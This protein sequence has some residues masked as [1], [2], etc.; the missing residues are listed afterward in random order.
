MKLTII[1]AALISLS[2]PALAKPG[3]GGGVDVKTTK[4][5]SA[6]TKAALAGVGNAEAAAEITAQQEAQATYQMKSADTDFSGDLSSKEAQVLMETLKSDPS[7]AVVPLFKAE[8]VSVKG[9]QE[10]ATAC[11]I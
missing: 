7:L 1:L 3:R 2:L 11:K 8:N 9:L 4:A 10:A 6:E 5:V